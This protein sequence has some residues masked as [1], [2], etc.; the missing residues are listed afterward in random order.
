MVS[1]PHTKPEMVKGISLSKSAERTKDK[2]VVIPH[3]NA[4]KEKIRGIVPS[5]AKDLIYGEYLRELDPAEHPEIALALASDPDPRFNLFLDQLS[6]PR[7][8]RSISRP[9]RRNVISP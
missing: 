9:S 8:E 6:T 3:R 4:G 5:G 2:R 1:M 7:G